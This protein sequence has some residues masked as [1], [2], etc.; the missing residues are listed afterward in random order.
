MQAYNNT[1]QRLHWLCQTIAKANR[2]YVTS[3]PD[4][5]HTNLYYDDLDNRIVGR[6]INN[7]REHMMLTL[8]LE[9]LYFEW[10]NS[11][12]EVVQSVTTIDKVASDIEN[13]LAAALPEIYLNPQGFTDKLHF[14][15]PDYPFAHEPIEGLSETDIHEWKTY[16]KLANVLCSLVLGYLEL[17]SE[18]RIWPH[19]FDTGIYVE[20]GE[21]LGLG[22]G[23]AM[24]DSMAGAPYF[25]LSGYPIHG[26][27]DYIDLPTLANG[28]WEV[29]EH[30]QGAILPLNEL[31]SGI[32]EENR[33]VITDFLLKSINWCLRH[34]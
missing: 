34:K 19:H 31:S 16:R 21:K 14:Q 7:G 2:T 22:F 18:I 28:R 3:R 23:L 1:D 11:A 5:S 6:W 17:E 4:D 29:G 20:V 25:Y 26:T 15:I 13:E 33:Q 10:L 27:L 12:K 8:N 32:F 24:E 9:N 30:W